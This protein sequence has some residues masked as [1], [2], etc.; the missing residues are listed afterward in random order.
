V[1][2]TIDT[3]SKAS[4]KVAVVVVPGSEMQTIFSPCFSEV[5][6]PHLAVVAD[7]EAQDEAKILVMNSE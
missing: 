5:V 4:K 2:L 1:K 6:D 7:L 3:V